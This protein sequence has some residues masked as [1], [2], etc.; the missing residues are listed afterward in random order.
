MLAFWLSVGAQPHQAQ[1]L[2]EQARLE[3]GFHQC[4]S[5]RSGAWLYGWVGARRRELA[6]YA[7]TSGCPPLEAQLRFARAELSRAP[8]SGFWREPPARC[9][10]ALRAC[11]GRGMCGHKRGGRG[12]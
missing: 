9:L 2:T 5:N 4:V 7:G 3:S 11:F 12:R 10:R 8:Y 1:A 6:E